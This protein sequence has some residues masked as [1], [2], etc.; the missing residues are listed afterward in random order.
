M[1]NNPPRPVRLG[2]FG[3]TGGVLPGGHRVEEVRDLVHAPHPRSPEERGDAHAAGDP[4]HRPAPARTEPQRSVRPLDH[5]GVPHGD[6]PRES[7]APVTEIADHDAHDTVPWVRRDGEGMR[8]G[9]GTRTDA[10]EDELPRPPV[11]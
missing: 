9:E 6:S 11:H 2:E 10:D 3:E 8:L 4:H 1:E 7:T 5:D